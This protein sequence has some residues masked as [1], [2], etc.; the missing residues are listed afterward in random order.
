MIAYVLENSE[1]NYYKGFNIF[2][3]HEFVKELPLALILPTPEFL[4]E[5]IKANDFTDCKITQ[6]ELKNYKPKILK[7]ASKIFG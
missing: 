2:E 1:G 3:E 5:I 7:N 4:V 6:V